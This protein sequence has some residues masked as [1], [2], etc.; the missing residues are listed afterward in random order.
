MKTIGIQVAAMLMIVPFTSASAWTLDVDVGR[1]EVKTHRFATHLASDEDITVTVPSFSRTVTVVSAGV[2]HEMFNVPVSVTL[3]A[4]RTSRFFQE[5]PAP[6]PPPP[7]PP[8]PTVMSVEHSVR[9][10]GARFV[11]NPVVPLS[12]RWALDGRF[13]VQHMRTRLGY[14]P[15]LVGSPR[16]RSD[17]G[18][19]A[20]IG[21]S[22]SI[23]PRIGVRLGADVAADYRAVNIGIRYSFD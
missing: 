3:F 6:M 11:A 15:G 8:M 2:A 21:V 23:A 5:Y 4:S 22:Y 12:E 13:G 1:A 7:I 18:P 17:T 10:H 19:F 9:V 16:K 20:G 14:S